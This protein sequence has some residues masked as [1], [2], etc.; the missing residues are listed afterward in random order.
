MEKKAYLMNVGNIATWF[1]QFPGT[2]N[3]NFST[4]KRTEE[5]SGSEEVSVLSCDTV[6]TWKLSKGEDY[7]L[8]PYIK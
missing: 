3:D 1:L 2:V 6:R 5:K 4:L 7:F 8:Y